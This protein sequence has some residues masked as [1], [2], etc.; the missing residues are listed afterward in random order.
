MRALRHVSLPRE[1]SVPGT[2]LEIVAGRTT[3][4]ILKASYF[5]R[6]WR[7]WLTAVKASKPPTTKR[8]SNL[9]FSKHCAVV[10]MS[11]EGR[12]RFVP[13]SEPPSLTQASV[14]TQRTS[15]T[16][17]TG[18]SAWWRIKP[19][20]PLWIAIGVWPRVKQYATAA[21]EAW[22]MPPAG[23]PTW[24]MAMRILCFE[25]VARISMTGVVCVPCFLGG[26]A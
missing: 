12:P 24:T 15:R 1:Y 17:L 16:E 22:F 5:S 8:A 10:S 3:M 25:L 14:S 19:V 6:A 18:V 23:A 13:M 2:L 4:G 11:S 21:R 26:R 7:S 9:Y 20:N